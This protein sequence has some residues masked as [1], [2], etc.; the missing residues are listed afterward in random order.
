MASQFFRSLRD[1][2]RARQYARR[3]EDTYVYWSV[4]FIR[5]HNMRHPETMGSDEVR[6]LM[7]AIAMAARQ[8]RRA[9]GR[10]V[11]T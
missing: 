11:L 5:F 2:L 9:V 8:T 10:S 7:R 1:H 6:A 4:Q 3:T